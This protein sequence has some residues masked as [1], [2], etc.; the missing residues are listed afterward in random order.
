MVRAGV[1]H[2]G[3]RDQD[4]RSLHQEARR[5]GHIEL[6][7][8]L[9]A[10]GTGLL[11]HLVRSLGAR[12]ARVVVASPSID[13]LHEY[14]GRSRRDLHKRLE[15]A[16]MVRSL[17][18]LEDLRQ[19]TPVHVHQLP[20]GATRYFSRSRANEGH[21]R[22]PDDMEERTYI[23][24]DRQ[25]IAAYWDYMATNQ[26]RIPVRLVTSDLRL[27][28][29]CTAERVPF[30]F[31]R[32]PQ[33]VRKQSAE[34][35][36][37]FSLRTLFFDPFALAL[38]YTTAQALLFELALIF[39][40]IR[41]DTTGPGASFRLTYHHERALPGDAP[42]LAFE[43]IAAIAPEGR[44]PTPAA[45]T[46]VPLPRPAPRRPTG[47]GKV[48]LTMLAKLLGHLR[49]EEGWS[50]ADVSAADRELLMQIGSAT[51]LFEL[52]TQEVRPGAT[53]PQLLA[54]LRQGD[55]VAA[56]QIFRRYPA[57]DQVLTSVAKGA[58]FPRSQES[59]GALTGWAVGLGAAYKTKDGVLYGLRKTSSKEFAER[60]RAVHEALGAGNPAVEL[61]AI[62]DGVCRELKMS[63]IRF[64]MHLEQA[65]AEQG[66]L[67]E[68]YEV[69]RASV[70]REIPDHQVLVLGEDQRLLLRKVEPGRG[71]RLGDQLVSSL[72]RR[73]AA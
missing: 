41:V 33:E 44:E 1:A 72:V 36:T 22:E 19:L 21:A 69:H 27:S 59:L 42:T 55:Y 2:P 20:P 16:D 54:R 64:E 70:S 13:V 68:T 39:N 18:V 61:P 67:R 52:A 34:D 56:N 3:L 37:P 10:L 28:R 5:A 51:G 23:S 15:A 29:V 49:Q 30:L 32:T 46:S 71:V 8:D 6:F 17:R 24:E 65:L 35:G 38:R 63:P 12:V 4:L 58:P 43:P 7:T 60:V 9:N 31:S 53:Y 11:G 73:G 45:P 57:Y 62:L 48:T 50:E 14:Q 26:P 47:S 40:R 25:M 66:A